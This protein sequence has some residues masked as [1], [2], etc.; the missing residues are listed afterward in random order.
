M[1]P[2]AI[3]PGE[4]DS[5]ESLGEGKKKSGLSRRWSKDQSRTN[6]YV[7]STAN[8]KMILCIYNFVRG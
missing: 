5:R 7:Y 6:C 1:P 8:L 4:G 3:T 2:S